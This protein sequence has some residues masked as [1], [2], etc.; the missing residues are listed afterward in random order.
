M[1]TTP[2]IEQSSKILPA[3]TILAFLTD[4]QFLHPHQPLNEVLQQSVQTTGV[5]PQ[6]IEQT[7]QKLQLKTDQ[8]IG[9]LRRSELIQ[10]AR[11]IH[12]NWKQA[13]GQASSI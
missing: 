10:L 3:E 13:M 11:G 2:T 7:L 9:R 1:S 5:C 6:A 12:R 4:N 8:L